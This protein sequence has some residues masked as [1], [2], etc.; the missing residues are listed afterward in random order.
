MV[1]KQEELAHW[2][3]ANDAGCQVDVIHPDAIIADNAHLPAKPVQQVT[4][5]GMC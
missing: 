2:N 1:S 5:L 3:A 4:I